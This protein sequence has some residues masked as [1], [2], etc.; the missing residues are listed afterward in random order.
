MI[1]IVVVSHSRALANAVV[2]LAT[3][4]VPPESRPVVA[5]A[6]GLDAVTF[7]TDASAIAEA[8]TEVDS[9]DGVLVFLDLGSAV[10]SAEMAV[11]FLD[12]EVARHVRLTPAPLVEGLVAAMVTASTGATVD[13]VDREARSGL[14]GKVQHLQGDEPEAAGGSGD[15]GVPGA[16]GPGDDAAAPALEFR[17]TLTNPHGLH[18]RPAAAVVSALTGLDAEVRLRNA[19]RGRGPA[20]ADSV[21][22][23]STLDLR[24]GDE[25]VARAAGPDAAAALDRLRELAGRSF[26]DDA[27]TPSDTGDTPTLAAPVTAPVARL[28]WL[29]DAADGH[30]GAPEAELA[31]FEDAHRRVDDHLAALAARPRPAVATVAPAIFGAQRALLSDRSLV[32]SIRRDIEGGASVAASVTTRCA[33]Q[34][35][36]FESLSDPYLQERAQDLRQIARLLTL[37]LDD[38]PLGA[39]LPDA[40]HVLAG[41]ELDA[42][43]AAALDPAATLVVVTSAAGRS[44]HGA[45]LAAAAGVPLVTGVPAAAQWESGAVVTVHPD[46]SVAA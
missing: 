3:E 32:R 10:L 1:G 6:A 17:H 5:V 12:P 13:A 8:I 39:D 9:P 41:H 37:A 19:T 25:L 44:G 33:E 22:Q 14:A 46:G 21:V 11:E 4:M 2:A 30:P 40:P 7:G 35:S 38:R 45:I 23:I 28:P 42:A 34:A 15:A 18:A 43:T 29:P 36:R 20:R 31:R 16:S 26:G 24:Q 27:A